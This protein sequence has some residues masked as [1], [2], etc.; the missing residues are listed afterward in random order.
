MNNSSFKSKK[1]KTMICSTV[2]LILLACIF[3]FV[4][5]NESEY[6]KQGG[7]A[8]NGIVAVIDGEKIT[9]ESFESYKLLL[10]N[11]GDNKRTDRQILDKIIE[12]QVIYNQAVKEGLSVSEAEVNAA[13]SAAREVLENAENR[14]A[15]LQYLAT[16]NSSEDAYW[17]EVKPVYRK[18]LLCGK[19][20][21]QLKEEFKAEKSTQATKEA[22]STFADYYSHKIKELI[23]RAKLESY[24]D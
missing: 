2:V 11:T 7:N 8:D 17:S 4:W 9:K 12:G 23:S 3:T 21:N 5:V 13:I 6:I 19:Y 22:S 20:K 14:A 16:L 18:S 1:A 10:S 24:F 15:F